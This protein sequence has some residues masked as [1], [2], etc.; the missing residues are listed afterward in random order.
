MNAVKAWS[1]SAWDVYNTCPLKYKFEKIDKLDRGPRPPAMERGDRIHK[2]LAAYLSKQ[3][4]VMP[5]IKSLNARKVYQEIRQYDDVIVEKQWGFTR[6]WT[7]TG[8]F[9]GA[10]GPTWLRVILDVGVLYED[11]SAEVVDHKTGKPRGSYDDQMEIFGVGVMCQMPI[12]NHVTA[13]LQ[14]TDHEKEVIFEFPASDKPK[15]IAKWE[16]KV[17]PLFT[18]EVF[19][20]RPGDHCG[21]CNFSR[22]KGGKCR[23]G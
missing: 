12:V 8:W 11:Y 14:F 16:K 20:P 1:F 10:A 19:N 9:G 7:S 17:E 13:R 2:E 6:N 5:D 15:I 3:T 4:D 18:D 22:S 23:Y 21:F